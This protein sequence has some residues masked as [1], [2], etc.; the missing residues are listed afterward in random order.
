MLNYTVLHA[1]YAV[2]ALIG[3]LLGCVNAAYIVG[4]F[5]GRDIR[6]AGSHNAGATNT[7]IVFGLKA[8]LMVA[9]IDIA[10]AVIAVMLAERLFGSLLFAGVVAG[11]SSVFGHAFP[12][13]MG[14]RGGKGFASFLG[15][16]LASSG[17]IAFFAAIGATA[18]ITV[19]GDKISVATISVMAS[20]P[21][22][23]YFMGFDVAAILLVSLASAAMIVKHREN[24][25]RLR[26]GEELGLRSYR[27]RRAAGEVAEDDI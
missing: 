13:W 20:Y 21:V 15:L 27:A 7:M 19:V 2:C 24:I 18:L 12:F 9:V 1:G 16:I 14:F 8:G 26:R 10:K 4:K 23:M 5:H 22:M 3:Y 6:K 25:A 11:V 17:W